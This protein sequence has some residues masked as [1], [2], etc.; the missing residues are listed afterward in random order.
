A[1]AGTGPDEQFFWVDAGKGGIGGRGVWE[2]ACGYSWVDLP[3]GKDTNNTA[4]TPPATGGVPANRLR[5]FNNDFIVGINWYQNPWSRVF[6]DYE[7]EIV[8][9]VDAGVPTSNAD[10][11]GVRWQI[12]W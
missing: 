11:F 6:F 4:A 5:G 9:F 1:L 12:D 2:F 7:H 8:D 3:D 10:I